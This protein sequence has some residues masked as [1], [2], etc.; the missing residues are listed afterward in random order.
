MRILHTIAEV[1]DFRRSQG[2]ATLG[3]VPTMGFLHEGH[4]AL[5]RQA[6]AE[7]ESVAVSIYVNPKQFG[8]TEDLSRYP[9]DLAR[10]LALLG[11]EGVDCVFIP[12]NEEMYPT[13]FQ[14]GVVV[15]EITQPL[16]GARRPT[17][18]EGVTTVVAKLFNIFQPTRAYFGQKD[19][20]Q[21]AVVRQMVRDLNFGL[22]IVVGPTVREADGLALSSR[23]KYLTVE[24]RATATVLHRAL[25][26]AEAHWQ[27]GERDSDAL[28]STMR[29]LLEAEPLARVDYVSAADPATLGEYAGLIPPG[30]GALLSMAVFFDRTRLIDNVLLS[31]DATT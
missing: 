26:S 5:V 21:V 6:R 16:E 2:Q 24:Q 7:N 30:A 3:L 31:G 1:R 13:D 25:R 22:G 9:R 14:S 17:H 19:A 4:L 10:D 8:P 27:S 15:K 12:D 29:Q 18:F 28:R 20:Q 23:N 11:E